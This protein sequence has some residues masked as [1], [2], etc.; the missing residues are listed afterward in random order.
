MGN[1]LPASTETTPVA[2]SILILSVGS[3]P[4]A[5][6]TCLIAHTTSSGEPFSEGVEPWKAMLYS[7]RPEAE[8]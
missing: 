5:G 2:G 7:I 3:V 1:S 4:S 6:I 8:G